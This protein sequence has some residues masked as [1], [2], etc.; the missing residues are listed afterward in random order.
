M[1]MEIN[2]L[3]AQIKAKTDELRNEKNEKAKLQ[4]KKDE[5]D[6]TVSSQKV[7]IM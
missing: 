1:Q 6:A 4:R 5:G 7:M 2:Q 3:K